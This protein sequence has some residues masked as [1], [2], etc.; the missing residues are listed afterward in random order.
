MFY[1]I[2]PAVKTRFIYL[3]RLFLLLMTFFIISRCLFLAFQFEQSFHMGWGGFFGSFLYGL[4]LDLSIIGYVMLLVSLVVAFSGV[5]PKRII[6]PILLVLVSVCLTVFALVVIADAE[7]YRHWGFRMDASVMIYLNTPGEML[8]S[9]PVW[10]SGVFFVA[11]LAYSVLFVFFYV[12]W[13]GRLVKAFSDKNYSSIPVFIAVSAFMILPIRGSIGIAPVNTGM[14]YFSNDLFHNHSAINVVWNFLYDW[15]NRDRTQLKVDLMSKDEAQQMR[16]SMVAKTDSSRLV[17]NQNRPNVLFVILEGFSSQVIKPLGGRHGV[18]PCLNQL[19][20]EG[21]GFTNIYATGLR[22]DRGLVAV[23]SGY[24]SHPKASVMKYPK[25]TEKLPSICREFNKQ[26]YNSVYY[27]GGDTHFANMNSFIVNSGFQRTVNQDYFPKEYRNS[28]WG[29][30]DEY[31]FE[32]VLAE[33]D[34]AKSPFF[35]TVFTLSSHEPF[36]VPMLTKIKGDQPAEK[37]MNSVFY[38]DSCLGVFISEAKKREWWKNTLVV[39][40]SDHSVRYP[41]EFPIDVPQRYTIPML[42]LGG[43]IQGPMVVD[44]IGNQTDIV[45]TVLSQMGMDSKNF[46]FS[47]DLLNPE[48][49]QFAMFIY[50]QGFGMVTPLGNAV[51]NMDINKFSSAKGDTTGI[52]YPSKALFQDIIN[53]FNSL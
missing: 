38:A 49:N 53:N 36:D 32:R 30:H 1:F 34:T 20:D 35:K 22:S 43:A 52:T 5:V 9:L 8:A 37:Y 27:Y 3:L 31:I 19:W 14:V 23:L 16:L 28:K 11:W 4:R 47:N 41:D 21:I 10:Q 24:P 46:Y 44:A 18:T 26:G 7:L 39:L 25:K 33:A 17:L 50:N 51:F 15:T 6:K 42:W 48:R 40:V 2:F 45:A 29:V 13:V 12:R